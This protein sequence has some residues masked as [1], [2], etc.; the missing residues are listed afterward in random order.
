MNFLAGFVCGFLVMG[1][2][3]LHQWETCKELLREVR[4]YFEGTV[5]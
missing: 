2:T 5:R 4:E 1:I 3:T